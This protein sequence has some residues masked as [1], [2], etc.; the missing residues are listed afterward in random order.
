[1]WHDASLSI[2]T[3]ALREGI[4][5][6]FHVFTRFPEEVRA[7]FARHGLDAKRLEEDDKLRISDT[8]TKQTGLGSREE[9][10]KVSDWSIGW[11]KA[12]KADIPEAEKRWL[13]IDDDT[14]VVL[15]YNKEEECIDLWRT[16]LIPY[17]RAS[18]TVV[19]WGFLTEAASIGFYR[20]LESLCDGIVSFRSEEKEG[21]IEQYVRVSALR[22]ARYDSR[23]RKLELLDN[24][25]V[26]VA[27]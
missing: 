6:V 11:M 20:K 27:D 5:T 4:R 24:G 19:L 26:A 13:H 9:S 17:F 14:S 23:W 1:L 15:Q 22:G 12:L 2:A 25:E 10:M 18:E 8:Y 16:R 21:R 3:Q 7:D